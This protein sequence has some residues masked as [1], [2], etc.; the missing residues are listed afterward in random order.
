MFVIASEV[1]H[2]L[3]FSKIFSTLEIMA[4]LR[5]TMNILI[6]GVALYYEL[7]VVFG[8][9]ASIFSLENK[10]MI[11]VD[12]FTKQAIEKKPEI[13]EDPLIEDL[14]DTTGHSL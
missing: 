1:S 8:R 3:T 10:S 6:N 13:L 14:V 11:E 5:N 4:S 7:K 9:F 2:I 12:E